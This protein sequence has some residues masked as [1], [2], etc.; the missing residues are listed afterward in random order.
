MEKINLGTL[1]GS[2]EKRDAVHIAVMPML[3]LRVLKPGERLQHGIVDP[4]LT[5]PVQPGE[6]YYLLLY[7]NTVTSLRH[8]WVHPAFPDEPLPVE[9]PRRSERDVWVGIPEPWV[10]K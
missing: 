4:F 1:I 6:H 8:V 9:K 2:N 7:P 3:A 10:D 5:Q